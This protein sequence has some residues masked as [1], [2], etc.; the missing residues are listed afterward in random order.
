MTDNA[1]MLTL[2]QLA[3]SAFPSGAVSFSSGLE[4]LA[5]DGL[6]GEAEYAEFLLDT[7]RHRWDPFDRVYLTRSLSAADDAQ[8]CKVDCDLDAS[9]FIAEARRA[10]RRAGMALLGTWARLGMPAAQ[11]YRALVHAGRGRGHLAV[12]QGL[13]YSASGLGRAA[14]EAASCWSL[15]TGL[16]GA[17]IRLGVVGSLSAQAAL[18][19]IR[20][21]VAALLAEPMSAD[22]DPHAWTPLQDIAFARHAHAELRLFA[23]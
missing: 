4:A 18:V 7:L 14:S 22:R 15:L 1:E 16:T 6:V 8:R 2:L 12:A 9:T 21:H 19:H 3:D 17:A 10:S 20:P 11:D 13:V 5:A 23:S